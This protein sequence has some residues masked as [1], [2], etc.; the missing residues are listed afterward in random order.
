MLNSYLFLLLLSNFFE[1]SNAVEDV[2][3][4]LRE[5]IRKE[6]CKIY[7]NARIEL[8]GAFQWQQGGQPREWDKLQIYEQK[9]KGLISFSLKDKETSK[10]SQGSVLFAAW[11]PGVIA[12]RRIQPGE[13]LN[14]TLFEQQ[15]LNVAV[16]SVHDFRGLLVPKEITVSTLEARQTIMEGQFLLTSAVRRIPDIRK[17]D[18]V[19]IVIVSGGL[20]L[21]TT[22]IAEESGYLHGTLRV[23]ASKTKKILVGKLNSSSSVEVKL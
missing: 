21:V 14:D 10:T 1:T 9:G 12:I 19:Q 18:A 7:S 23:L 2:T 4:Q 22:G 13:S 11:V 6:I 17:G 20:T 5:D 8:T 16:G 15:D 3:D